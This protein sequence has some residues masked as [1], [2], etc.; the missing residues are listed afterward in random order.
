MASL[1]YQQHLAE[2]ADQLIDWQDLHGSTHWI[3]QFSQTFHAEVESV[4]GLSNFWRFAGISKVLLSYIS[5]L[6]SLTKV[7]PSLGIKHHLLQKI[8]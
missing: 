4:L 5:F 3:I 7:L 2:L 1:R 8:V 6:S